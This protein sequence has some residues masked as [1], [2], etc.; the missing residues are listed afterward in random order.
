MVSVNFRSSSPATVPYS[1]KNLI[2]CFQVVFCLR[3]RNLLDCCV[4]VQCK[5][6]AI[7][8]ALKIIVSSLMYHAL[9][10]A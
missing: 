8:S 6:N 5:K 10:S 7:F 2:V 4:T 9:T 3:N 1:M